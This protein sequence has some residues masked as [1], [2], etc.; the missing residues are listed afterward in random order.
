MGVRDRALG[1][2]AQE[3]QEAAELQCIDELLGF[4]LREAL[5]VHEHIPHERLAA[6]VANGLT[7]AERVL[8]VGRQLLEIEVL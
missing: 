2:V 7:G 4:E 3:A 6:Q 1:R 8:E 5:H